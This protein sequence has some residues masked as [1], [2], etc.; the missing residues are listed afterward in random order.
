MLRS[1]LSILVLIFHQEFFLST[2][3]GEELGGNK[4]LDA[5]FVA[6]TQ[7]NVNN[8]AWL[9]LSE[10]ML[11][12][13]LYEPDRQCFLEQKAD[14]DG[15]PTLDL[16]VEA[17]FS[18]LACNCSS[19]SCCN[20]DFAKINLA[21][22]LGSPSDFTQRNGTQQEASLLP[23]LSSFCTIS[24]T[25]I[26]SACPPRKSASPPFVE[27]VDPDDFPVLED[28]FSGPSPTGS[29]QN[30]RITLSYEIVIF[31]YEQQTQ[32]GNDGKH[33]AI[34]DAL[35]YKATPFL[36]ASMDQLTIEIGFKMFSTVS[37]ARVGI[38]TSLHGFQTTSEAIVLPGSSNDTIEEIDSANSAFQCSSKPSNMSVSSDPNYYCQYVSASVQLLN[39]TASVGTAFQESL[40]EAVVDGKLEGI[41]R[42]WFPTISAWMQHYDGNNTIKSGNSQFGLEV[43]GIAPEGLVPLSIPT[44]D[45]TPFPTR[46]AGPAGPPSQDPL[47]PRGDTTKRKGGS[48]ALVVIA[49]IIG[50][51]VVISLCYYVYKLV[52]RRSSMGITEKP[53]PDS[54]PSNNVTANNYVDHGTGNDGDLEA[55]DGVKNDGSIQNASSPQE[56]VVSI[57]YSSSFPDSSSAPV[58]S[59]ESASQG[60]ARGTKPESVIAESSLEE[61][62]EAIAASCNS[63]TIPAEKR[64]QHDF[65]G[66]VAPQD[67]I[68]DDILNDDSNSDPLRSFDGME[69]EPSVGS[70]RS[71][72]S[73]MLYDGVDYSEDDVPLAP[74]PVGVVD[75][76]YV[77]K[78]V[79]HGVNYSD[80][81]DYYMYDDDDGIG[82]PPSHGA[83]DEGH[84]SDED[85]EKLRSDDVDTQETSDAHNW[86]GRNRMDA[87]IEE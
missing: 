47:H 84:P 46:P 67:E 77:A 42:E 62:F 20:D 15:V 65:N 68:E 80:D 57:Q 58:G 36:V 7:A 66:N 33:P 13:P 28:T 49:S 26:V 85:D 61:A 38:P 78:P 63:E 24:G 3:R 12:V 34:L 16:L 35:R 44:P 54:F 71:P 27:V 79:Y 1:V 23:S 86:G 21:R 30:R 76:E 25:A 75:P 45:P 17:A 19:Q 56:K 60:V 40:V 64:G 18:T 83:A 9:D 87:I 41:L 5:C 14:A 43:I 70:E 51:S 8:D 72:S 4:H 32:E 50:G 39:A 6:L 2:S 48:M 22:I 73:S 37:S 74:I 52:S 53:R 82:E 31:H 29:S 59:T 10:Y 11:F 81:D 69:F 55:Y